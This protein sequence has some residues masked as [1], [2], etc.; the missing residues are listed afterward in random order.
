MGKYCL[1]TKL[2]HTSPSDI[3][4]LVQ[5]KRINLNLCSLLHKK[6]WFSYKNS[7]AWADLIA[8]DNWNVPSAELCS[9]PAG[10]TQCPFHSQDCSHQDSSQ[11]GG[12]Y[13]EFCGHNWAQTRYLEP[14][15]PTINGL[16][17]SLG[18]PS[19]S[20]AQPHQGEQQLGQ[21]KG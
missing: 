13:W 4:I 3:T 14:V 11:S 20:G 5:K 9:H 12:F 7:S 16:T 17:P 8:Q 15:I 2:L 10:R 18:S 19:S 6:T 21:A 1:S